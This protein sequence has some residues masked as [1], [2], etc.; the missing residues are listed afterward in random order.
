MKKIVDPFTAYLP[1]LDL[2]AEISS[3]SA[4]LINDFIN[5]NVKMKNEKVIIIHGKG[6][7]VLKNTTKKVLFN[8]KN[9]SKFYIDGF[10]DG[11]TIV[12][13]KIEK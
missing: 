10:N 6:S 4:F 1:H 7:G 13:L 9:V 11:Q 8:N 2:H 5:D 3:I 12:E